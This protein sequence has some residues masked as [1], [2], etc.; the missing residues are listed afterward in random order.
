MS[1]EARQIIRDAMEDGG[2]KTYSRLTR[3][4]EAGKVA[5]KILATWNERAQYEPVT[6]TDYVNSPAIINDAIKAMEQYGKREFS[7]L[8]AEIGEKIVIAAVH[9]ILSAHEPDGEEVEQQ[10]YHEG[11]KSEDIERRMWRRDRGL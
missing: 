2:F 6:E 11:L 3:G 4:T 9:Y 1:Y 10:I 8:C 5:V 7:E